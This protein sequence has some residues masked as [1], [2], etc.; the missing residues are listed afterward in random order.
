MT[1][2]SPPSAMVE[3][4]DASQSTRPLPKPSRRRA[5]PQLSCNLC[6]R[7]KLKC[8]RGQPCETCARRGLS[9][10][11][12]YVHSNV[13]EPSD[14]SQLRPAA[15]TSI[16]D[17]IGQLESLVISLMSNANVAKSTYVQSNETHSST[18]FLSL[19]NEHEVDGDKLSED[20][21]SQFSDSFGR[22]SLENSET[23]YVES[24]HWT[25]ILDGIAELKDYFEDDHE[26]IERNP[27][28]TK[29]PDSDGPDLLLGQYKYVNKQEILAA[30]PSR[31]IVDR[32]IFKYFHMM[33]RIPSVVIHSPT[34][35]KEYEQFWDHPQDTPVMWIGLLFAIMCLSVLHQQFSP[36]ASGQPLYVQSAADSKCLIEIYREKVVQ[37]LVLG[38][39]TKSVPYTIET[40]LLYL[41]IE[42]RRSEDTQ[43]GVWIILGI[44]VRMALHMGYHRDASHFPRISPFHAEMRRRAWAIIV[45]LDIIA[46][47]QVG[48]P[49]MIRVSQSDTAE[50]RNLLDEDFDENVVELPPE[51][52]DT[53]KTP[54]LCMVVKNRL[55]SVFGMI[56]DLT[57]STRPSSYAEVMRLDQVLHD[58]YN[59]I[60]PGLR[61]RPTTKSDRPDVS[62]SAIYL[63]ILFHKCQCVLHRKYMLPARTNSRY[64][65]SRKTCIEAAL[66]M[67]QYQWILNEET[68]SDGRLYQDRWIVLSSIKQEF[69][70]ATTILCLDLNH[71][72]TAES[73]SESQKDTP[74]TD[75]RERVIQALS[76]SYLIWLQSRDSS[77][78]A[79]KAAEVLRIV[80]GKAQHMRMRGSVDLG[81][82]VTNIPA[83]RNDS[84]TSSTDPSSLTATG[85]TSH[86]GATHSG[87]SISAPLLPI[88]LSNSL[89]L[90]P[91]TFANFS[92]IQADLFDVE[93]WDSDY[94]ARSIDDVLEMSQDS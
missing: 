61:M 33:D 27:L 2:F 32:L 68:Q 7:R 22:I 40:L 49:R 48:L 73:S 93:N 14:R 67:L 64:T 21:P 70:L 62:L 55:F 35:L 43:I 58:T 51:R 23:T 84:S 47:T 15:S 54:I 1:T 77:R 50:P 6:R 41:H 16:H 3:R 44:I 29:V 76:S 26:H 80:L 31:P 9:L 24:A 69:L 46:S 56:S 90:D 20:P 52:P 74:D 81:R 60:S 5:K 92:E 25:A 38:K 72:I 37:C 11:C 12:S 34:F 36:S 39:Y 82:S 71:D 59:N 17:R 78:E 19:V 13:A 65:Y 87:A 10:S 86:L 88:N 28:A 89:Q 30:I 85:L 42:Y 53:D 45:Q 57:T 91:A 4:P 75:T 63:A 66:H 83:A 8:D 94:Q 79:Q 18:N